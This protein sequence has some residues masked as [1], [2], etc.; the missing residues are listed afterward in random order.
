MGLKLAQ[1]VSSLEHNKKLKYLN[2]W[3]LLLDGDEEG[4]DGD[5][6]MSMNLLTIAGTTSFVFL[7]ELLEA[8]LEPDMSDSNERTPLKKF[9]ARR[10]KEHKHSHH[11]DVS[12]MRSIIPKL[13]W[14]AT[15]NHA[16]CGVFVKKRRIV[17]V[18][19]SFLPA[20]TILVV[21]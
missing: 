13:K 10:L 17:A 21:T 11:D 7:D 12:K 4:V 14:R 19:A 2:A 3:S 15:K 8:R 6:N 1:H 16:D 9:L 18:P 20:A 5:P